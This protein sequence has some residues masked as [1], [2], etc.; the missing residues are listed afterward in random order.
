MTVI[1]LLCLVLCFITLA[2]CTPSH[3][4]TEKA[5]VSLSQRAY[6]RQAVDYFE[7]IA[8]G[9]E[10]GGAPVIRKWQHATI[11][12]RPFGTPTT[13]DLHTIKQVAQ[14]LNPLLTT[15]KVKVIS[16]GKANINVY[17]VP[18]YD[19]P[20]YI[21]SYHAGNLGYFNYRSN[22]KNVITHADVVVDSQTITQRIRNHLIR[23]EITQSFGLAKDSMRYSDS[24]FYQP[25]S[26][27]QAYSSLD[28]TIIQLLY[29]PLIHPG[30]T[31]SDIEKTLKP[32]IPN[33]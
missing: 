23:E 11:S 20:H 15:V 6:S 12:I 2:S 9:A 3:P 14:D 27:V 29:S 33:E 32:F 13:E 17:F 10:Y 25:A 26:Y 24:I 16:Q 19:F 30:M 18:E 7:A 4:S 1:R 8:L 31:K 22:D 5:K 28:K 21:P